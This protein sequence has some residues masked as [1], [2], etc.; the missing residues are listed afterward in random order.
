V[1]TEGDV[2]VAEG[3]NS[4]QIR[5]FSDPPRKRPDP[6]FLALMY[7]FC[8]REPPRVGLLLLPAG[9][10]VL[11]W[12]PNRHRAEAAVTRRPALGETS[13]RRRA[14]APQPGVPFLTLPVL[15]LEPEAELADNSY[16]ARYRDHA[17]ATVTSVGHLAFIRVTML[18]SCR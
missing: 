6:R 9:S 8:T 11:V 1:E 15:A 10:V 14:P 5:L 12:G 4:L 13:E 16:V 17:G 2:G 18:R 7:A 3:I